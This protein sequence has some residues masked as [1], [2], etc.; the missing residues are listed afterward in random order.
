MLCCQDFSST[1]LFLWPLTFIV[2]QGFL[3]YKA[4]KPACQEIVFWESCTSERCYQKWQRNKIQW[5]FACF[6]G[7]RVL[8]GYHILGSSF[9]HQLKSFVHPWVLTEH[10]LYRSINVQ[11][12]PGIDCG[13]RKIDIFRNWRLC[14]SVPSQV[15]RSSSRLQRDDKHIWQ[16]AHSMWLTVIM[17][18]YYIIIFPCG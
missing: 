16:H 15:D 12:G 1:P 3:W 6:R 14:F 7:R 10:K 2:T 17:L 8:G 13:V 4:V 11:S 5:N 18:F 9:L